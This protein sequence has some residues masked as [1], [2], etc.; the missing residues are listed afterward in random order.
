MHFMSIHLCKSA[1]IKQ[2]LKTKYNLKKVLNINTF[3]SK[4]SLRHKK[5][6]HFFSIKVKKLLQI[7]IN[8]WLLAQRCHNVTKWYK[9]TG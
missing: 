4:K 2:L 8:I 3:R 6:H 5:I 1:T 9:F 7:K